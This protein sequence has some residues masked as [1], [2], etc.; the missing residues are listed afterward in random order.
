MIIK[1]KVPKFKIVFLLWAVIL[2]IFIAYVVQYDIISSK[3]ITLGYP[4]RWFTIYNFLGGS[5]FIDVSS[6]DP[7]NFAVNTLL[8][9]LLIYVLYEIKVNISKKGH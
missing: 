7:V 3:F 1:N 4:L 6:L 9:Y 5:S 8:Y 2:N